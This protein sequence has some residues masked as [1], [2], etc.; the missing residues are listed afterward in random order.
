MG[1][2]LTLLD[3]NNKSADQLAHLLILIIAFV[4]RYLESIEVK[5]APGKIST[6]QLVFVAEQAGLDLP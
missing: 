6:F 1:E 4:I 3:V 5:L 2:N